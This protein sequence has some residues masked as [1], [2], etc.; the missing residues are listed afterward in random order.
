[1]LLVRDRHDTCVRRAPA[2]LAAVPRH[3]CVLWR[4]ASQPA[5]PVISPAGLT[6]YLSS[7]RPSPFTGSAK[8]LQKRPWPHGRIFLLFSIGRLKTNEASLVSNVPAAKLQKN[9]SR[10]RDKGRET[11]PRG[12]AKKGRVEM[13]GGG[14]LV[15]APTRI[16]EKGPAFRPGLSRNLMEIDRRRTA[17]AETTLCLLDWTLSTRLR[18]TGEKR[19]KESN[20]R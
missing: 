18:R 2:R 9:A 14:N 3:P 19:K 11:R 6:A 7:I 8:C 20:K 10:E 12:V 15:P 13:I 16:G 17:A 5:P 1:M 4:P